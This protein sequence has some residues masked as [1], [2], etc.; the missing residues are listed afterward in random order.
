LESGISEP[1]LPG[2]FIGGGTVRAPYDISP[3]G[4]QVVLEAV[5]R[6]GK[7]R[8]WVAPLDRRSPPRQIP[9]VE[10]DGPLFVPGGEILFRAREG[11]YG[12][13]YRVRQDGAG[14][15]KAH[16]HPV[17]G[18]RDVS[19]D[20]QWLVVYARPGQEE[21]GGA[22][23]LPLGGGPPVQVYGAG[24]DMKWS[25]DLKRVYLL[26]SDR[27][28]YVLPLPARKMFPEMP[29]GGFRSEAE[30]AS[31]PGVRIIDSPDVEPGPAPEV[32]AFSRQMV[33]RNLYRVP[34]P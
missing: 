1:L 23:A 5:D 19:P 32:Y 12:Y 3:D 4:R 10:G 17:I 2:F 14:L 24:I 28:T 16:E 6:D 7:D 25:P 22:L 31:L 33:Q 18:T 26:F 30:I 13:A 29:P 8:L 21:A 9:N 27:R 11:A 20:G 34:L 15:R